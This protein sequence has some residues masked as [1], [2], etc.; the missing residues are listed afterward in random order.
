M[1]NMDDSTKHA[2]DF[3]SIFT[4]IGT[5][6]SWLPHLAALFTIVWTGIRIYETKTVQAWVKKR[7]EKPVAPEA[8]DAKAHREKIKAMEQDDASKE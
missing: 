8:F 3:A 6:L 2:L 1:L 4:A 7:K 5:L